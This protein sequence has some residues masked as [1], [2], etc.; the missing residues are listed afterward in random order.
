M[1]LHDALLMLVLLYGTDT[2]VLRERSSI[3]AVNLDNLRG[4]KGVD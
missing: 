2:M 4:S 3:R 1:L